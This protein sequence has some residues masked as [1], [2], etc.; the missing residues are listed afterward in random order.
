MFNKQQKIRILSATICVTALGLAGCTTATTAGGQPATTFNPQKRVV[1]RAVERWKALT[2]KRF[3]SA[4]DYLSDA[5]KTGVTREEYASA[6]KRM[7]LISA[8]FGAAE[9]ESDELCTVNGEITLPVFVKNVGPR[10][11]TIPLQER[12]I[13]NNNELWLIR[14]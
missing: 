1:Q 4:Y 3:E 7:G 10:P 2:D 5:S 9:C 11:Q 12:W 8:Q 6:M 13:V 14:R